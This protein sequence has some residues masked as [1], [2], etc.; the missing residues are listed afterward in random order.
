MPTFCRVQALQG[1]APRKVTPIK[2]RANQLGKSILA[3]GI[4][5]KGT[6]RARRRRH[7]WVLCFLQRG[8]LPGFFCGRAYSQLPTLT[9]Q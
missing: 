5:R 9:P 8:D 7:G 2:T 1:K 6:A 3:G 4:Q